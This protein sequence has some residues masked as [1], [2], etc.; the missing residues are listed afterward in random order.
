MKC[1]ETLIEVAAAA[2]AGRAGQAA[3]RVVPKG[4]LRSPGRPC[5]TLNDFRWLTISLADGSLANPVP[6][7]FVRPCLTPCPTP[8]P[9]CLFDRE[10]AP[11]ACV[12][13]K[14]RMVLLASVPQAFTRALH[15]LLHGLL[16]GIYTRFT[17]AFTR[18]F[19]R[20]LHALY[21]RFTRALH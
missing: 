7:R 19:T 11:F 3:Q 13:V 4:R 5:S 14:S 10:I 9:L 20:T 6:L 8:L 16:H 1:C 21:T 12:T 15:A 17:R 18:A 2:A